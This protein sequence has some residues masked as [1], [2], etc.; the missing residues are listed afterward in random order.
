M[1]P[2]L[3]IFMLKDYVE[4]LFFSFIVYGF[5]R[6]LLYDPTKKLIPY[7]YLYLCALSGT[8]FYGLTTINF[9]LL[10]T[11]PGI[12][13]IFIL[14]H[15]ETLQKNLIGLKNIATATKISVDWTEPL[16]QILLHQMN[17]KKDM[18]CIIE[19]TDSL[20]P[21]IDAL[22]ELEAPLSM[23]LLSILCDS[24]SYNPTKMLWLSHGGIIKGVNCS[25]NSNTTPNF[26]LLYETTRLYTQVNDALF[27][28]T[29]AL[30]NKATIIMRG[31][32]E[33]EYS[34]QQLHHIIKKHRS[35][36][37][38]PKKGISYE[39]KSPNTNIQKPSA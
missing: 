20:L 34:I 24:P 12:I 7:F 14:A 6:W 10:L 25:W 18:M 3:S 17:H 39:H 9:F 8:H 35:S 31:V 23:D 36:Q 37:S 5:S 15:Q 27:F 30:S 4:I 1:I 32:I 29:H 16:V 22:F 11:I 19:K 21:F 13:S 38:L 26:P 33:K 28:H 2:F